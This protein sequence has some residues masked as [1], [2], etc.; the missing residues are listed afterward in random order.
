MAV[1]YN[2]YATLLDGYQDYLSSSDIY[3]EYWGFSEDPAKTEEEFETEQYQSLID[4]INR[5]PFDS[6]SADRG[7]AFNEIVDCIIENRKSG[8]MELIS[9]EN[10]ITAN[11]NN[12]SFV[13]NKKQTIEF[14]KK[15]NHALCQYKTE[16][17]ITTKYG[18]VL[19]YGYIDELMPQSVHDIK[20][21]SK[22]KSGKFRN[23]WQKIV[24]PYCL[25]QDGLYSESGIIEFIYNVVVWAY[26]KIDFTTTEEVYQYNPKRDIPLLI[27]HVEGFIEFLELNRDKITDKKIFN[28]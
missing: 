23:K 19:L 4:R 10:V 20:T 3:Q 26:N 28:L 11:F 25:N 5:V 16:A 15:F 22:Y 24:Y 17:I 27:T 7:T 12:R 8:K 21:T 13:F 18:D 9:N 14:A 6:E 1:K 2:I